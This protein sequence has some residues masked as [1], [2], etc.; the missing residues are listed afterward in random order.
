MRLWFAIRNCRSK[1]ERKRLNYGEHR[2]HR[3]F[4]EFDWDDNAE[5]EIKIE[6]KSVLLFA[7]KEGLISLANQL[8]ELSKE[9]Y[10]SGYHFHLDQ[11]NSLDEGS[12]EIIIGKQ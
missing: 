10:P 11:H 9:E 1:R 5:I 7:N 12:N 3:D 4:M 2:A 8:L 6:D